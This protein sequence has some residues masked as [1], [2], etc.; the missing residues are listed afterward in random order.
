MSMRKKTT[1]WVDRTYFILPVFLVLTVFQN[2]NVQAASLPSGVA[3]LKTT[4][5]KQPLGDL[6]SILDHVSDARVLGIG[7]SGHGVEEYT[8]FRSRLIRHL[9]EKSGYRLILLE[10][11]FLTAEKLNLYLQSCRTQAGGDSS[12]IAP[13]R[14][15]LNYLYRVEAFREGIEW[16]CEWNTQN[17]NDSVRFH[18]IDIWDYEWNVRDALGGLESKALHSEFTNRFNDAKQNCWLWG[19]NSYA[20]AEKTAEWAYLLKHWRL[21]PARHS[22]CLGALFDLRQILSREKSKF[23]SASNEYTVFLAQAL[24][25]I[26]TVGQMYRD[27]YIY[28]FQRMLDLRDEMQA[29]LVLRWMKWEKMTDKTVFLAHNVHVSKAQSRVVPKNPGSGLPGQWRNAR[30][31]GEFLWHHLG[32]KYKSIALTGYSLTSIRDGKYPNPVSTDSLDLMLS[33]IGSPYLGVDLSSSMLRTQKYWWM[34][35]EHDEDGMWMIPEE[36]Y[37]YA[38]FVRESGADKPWVIPAPTP[39]PVPASVL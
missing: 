9:V 33:Q 5:L 39:T 7:E 3:E 21:D 16:M 24:V 20:E 26:Q 1:G 17:P 27:G 38:I 11:P 32:G 30:S 2:F 8:R 36:Q 34:H 29:G 35:A 25:D 23:I 13:A 19:V 37:D 15:G 12:L 18:G 14:A 4:D 22:A 31:A 28:D 10:T 6:D